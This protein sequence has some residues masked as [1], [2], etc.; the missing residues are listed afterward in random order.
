MKTEAKANTKQAWL[1]DEGA[2]P[3]LPRRSYRG[4]ANVT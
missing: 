1:Q 3:L 4:P 2:V